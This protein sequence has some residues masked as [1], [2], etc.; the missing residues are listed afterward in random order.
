M[1]QSNRQPRGTEATTGKKRTSDE[2][3]TGKKRTS[4]EEVDRLYS[5]PLDEFIEARDELVK[6]RRRAGA[7]EEAARIKGLKKPNAAAWA[8]NQLIRGQPKERQALL[9]AADALGEAQRALGTGE[10]DA[11][12]LREATDAERRAV[13]ALVGHARALQENGHPLS[14]TTL[15]RVEE[16][17]HATALDAAARE[18]VESARLTRELSAVGFGLLETEPGTKSEKKEGQERRRSSTSARRKKIQRQLTSARRAAVREQGTA[19]AA[20]KEVKKATATRDQAQ[21]KLDRAEDKARKA[22][23]RQ[24]AAEGRVK[25]RQKALEDA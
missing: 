9:D 10:A 1:G 12:R 16:T 5:L 19:S 3:T 17:L 21:R 25:E 15:Q 18:Q 11:K 13:E 2:A 14:Q 23:D 4:D 6:R 20:R 7:G 22:E 8:V 24:Q